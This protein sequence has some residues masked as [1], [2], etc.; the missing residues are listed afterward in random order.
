VEAEGGPQDVDIRR[1]PGTAAR[2]S[3]RRGCR[4]SRG[5]ES[6]LFVVVS[7]LLLHLGDQS[8]IRKAVSVLVYPP[9]VYLRFCICGPC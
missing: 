4:A 6:T 8:K 9:T 1:H 5:M 2:A 3:A 7:C